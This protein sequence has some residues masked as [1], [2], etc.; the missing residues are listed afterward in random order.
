MIK[1]NDAYRAAVSE[2]ERTSYI[3]EKTG[4]I[5]GYGLLPEGNIETNDGIGKATFKIDVKGKTKDLKVKVHLSK[6]PDTEWVVH[7][8]KY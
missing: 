5:T 3:L 1:N 6:T 8:M 2:I 4:E 7:K